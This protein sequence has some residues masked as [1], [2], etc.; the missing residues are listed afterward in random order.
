MVAS[1][2]RGVETPDEH[3]ASPA[4]DGRTHFRF[5]LSQI[6]VGSGDGWIVVRSGHRVTPRSAR[7]RSMIQVLPAV[8]GR[9]ELAAP[10]HRGGPR[11]YV[12]RAW[13]RSAARVAVAAIRIG[14]HRARTGS[15]STHTGS[16]NPAT[17]S[18]AAWFQ[19]TDRVCRLL[20]KGR[21][22]GLPARRRQGA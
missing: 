10:R 17:N 7:N 13:A 8:A 3:A 1:R 18:A 20:R 16:V 2:N 19:G 15:E 6:S 5:T 22:G 21:P 4:N 14:K 11:V 12:R 9:S